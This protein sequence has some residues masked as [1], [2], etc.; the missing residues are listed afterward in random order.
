MGKYKVL[1]GEFADLMLGYYG[2]T[3]GEKSPEV[4]KMAEAHAKKQPITCRPADLLTPEWEH[5]QAQ[6]P[7]RWRVTTVRTKMC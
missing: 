3:I 5:L 4:L 1:T 2:S 6:R 7:R